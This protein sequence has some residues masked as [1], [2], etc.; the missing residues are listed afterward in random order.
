MGRSRKVAIDVGS[1][2]QMNERRRR[3]GALRESATIKKA[4]SEASRWQL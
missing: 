3:G 2:E 4:A 1:A